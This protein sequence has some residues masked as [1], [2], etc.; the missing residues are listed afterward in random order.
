MRY[1]SRASTYF[2]VLCCHFSYAS[3]ILPF[4]A[5][6]AIGM[7]RSEFEADSASSQVD[8]YAILLLSTQYMLD[9]TTQCDFALQVISY[10]NE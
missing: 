9:S 5:Y 2:A 4:Q 7:A 3:T 1:A 10:I 8:H 6:G